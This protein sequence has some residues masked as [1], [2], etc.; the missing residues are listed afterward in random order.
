M[1][2]LTFHG[3]AIDLVHI[4]TM[5]PLALL[6]LMLVLSILMVRPIVEVLYDLR[7]RSVKRL[8]VVPDGRVV[9]IP[10]VDSLA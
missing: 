8:N 1:G 5:L 7:V 4:A 9:R 6:L 10:L 3:G 2:N